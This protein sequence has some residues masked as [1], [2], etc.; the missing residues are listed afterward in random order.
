MVKP[1]KGAAIFFIFFGAMFLIPGLLALVTLLGNQRAAEQSGN[2]VAIA[3][4]LFISAVGAGFVWLAVAGYGRLKKL[5]AVEEANPTSPWLWRTD[6]ANGRADSSHKKS[7]ITAWVL[8][9]LFNVV[10]IPIAATAA[11]PLIRNNDPRAILVLGFSLLGLI[12]LVIAVRSTLRHRRYGNTYFEFDTLPFSPGGRLSGKIH[13]KMDTDAPHGVDLCASCIRK[14][15]T[16]SSNNRSTVQTVLWQT[17]QNISSG[18]LG[19]DPFGR[20]IPVDVAIPADAYVTDQENT[21]DQVVWI[22]HA[23]ADVPG[24]DYIDDFEVPV[25]RNAAATTPA[26]S[27]SASAN[28]GFSSDFK[29]ATSSFTGTDASTVGAPSHSKVIIRSQDGYTEFYFPAFRSP[30]RALF[31]L[32]FTAIW[33]GVVYFLFHSRAPWFFASIFGLFD[34][35]LVFGVFHTVLGTERI[36][37]GNGEVV[38]IKRVLGI[39]GAKR[40]PISEIDTILPVTS[41]GSGN[42]SVDTSYAIR[43]RTKSGKRVTLADEITSRQEARWIVSQLESLAGLQIDTRVEPDPRFGAPPQP[44]QDLSNATLSP[45]LR[46]RMQPGRPR[47]AASTAMSLALF[48]IVTAAM[49][50]WQGWRLAKFKASAAAR[51]NRA[52]SAAPDAMPRHFAGPMTDADAARVLAL[53]AE[54]QA[55]ELLERAIGHDE[56]ALGLFDQHVAEWPG[57]LHMTDRMKQL[58]RRS[59]YSNDLRVRYA[60]ADINLALDGWQENEQA[61]DML[62]QRAKTDEKYRAA[63]VYFLGM[64]AGRGVAYDKIHPV[65]LNYARND[66]DPYVRQWAVEG[67]RYLGKDEALDEL[68]ESFTH[69]PSIN[70]RNR[71]GCNLADCGNFTRVQRMRSVPKLIELISDVGTS[72][73]MRSWTYLA[74]REIT[75]VAVPSDAVSWKNWYRDH[76]AEKLAEFRALPWWQVRGDE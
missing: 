55:E 41:G 74:L 57:H 71:A 58:E 76:G 44:G 73:Q 3:I 52:R 67:M 22:L 30:S 19:M 29:P 21:S 50:G 40:F 23:K 60:N 54:D 56:R 65:L 9:I 24:I 1:S 62:I 7:E 48:V 49:F 33:S 53:P 42:N 32:F 34:V 43:L 20:T 51:T 38:S 75:S 10:I 45:A 2:L 14:T 66:A 64:L 4:A 63:A 17:D 31:I 11:P 18:A 35:L 70:V 28:Y 68:F 13:L 61:A 69:D 6:W 39:G 16:G 72:A 8:F 36:R 27:D 59:E 12:P 15:V 37:A 5:A 26:Q 47:S 25:F 46:F